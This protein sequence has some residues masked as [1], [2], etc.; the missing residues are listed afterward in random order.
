MVV[1]VFT[2]FCANA[3]SAAS[4][5]RSTPG[6]AEISE[7]RPMAANS[8]S[9]PVGCPCSSFATPSTAVVASTPQRRSAAV[10]TVHACPLAWATYTGRS[11]DTR[12]RSAA[13]SGRSG[14]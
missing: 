9:S 6:P 10:L 8:W 11:V 2:P 13:V 5:T 4:L 12:S 7:T 3:P 1:P 14:K